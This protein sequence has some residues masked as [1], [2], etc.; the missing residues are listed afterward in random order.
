MI[1]TARQIITPKVTGGTD[2][3]SFATIDLKI[4]VDY[5]IGINIPGLGGRVMVTHGFG[6]PSIIDPEGT[7]DSMAVNALK[8]VVVYLHN[9]QETTTRWYDSQTGQRIKNYN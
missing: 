4:H 9:G 6:K 5:A 1:A 3:G 8:D 7:I 2:A